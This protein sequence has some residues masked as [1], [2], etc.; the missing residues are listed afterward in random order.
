MSI[1]LNEHMTFGQ[2]RIIQEQ[3]DG[4]NLY[5]KGCF[6]QGDVRNHNGRIY[7][8]RE[9]SSAVG[10]MNEK[11]KAGHPILGECDHPSELTV[12]LKNVSHVITEINLEGAD[13]VGK[14]KILDTEYGKLA[15][16][17][18]EAGIP[19]GVSS[20]GSGNVDGSGMVS[21]FEIVTID[22]V[23]TPSAPDAYPRAIY[24]ALGFR[25]GGDKVETLVEAVRRDPKAQKY[26]EKSVLEWFKSL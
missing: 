1:I 14:M 15:R 25:H 18:I 16:T 13:G 5:L 26:L 19:L 9:I 17:L 10:K 24:E 20:R 12:S 7:P 11:I 8:L 21:D 22:L 2:A 3:D 23:A 6:I 4:K